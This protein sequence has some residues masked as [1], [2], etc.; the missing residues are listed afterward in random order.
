MKLSWKQNVKRVAVESDTWRWVDEK[1][2][3]IL[4]LSSDLI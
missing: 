2:F 3:L 1:L 4:V